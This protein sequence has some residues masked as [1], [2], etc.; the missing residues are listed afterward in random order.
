MTLLGRKKECHFLNEVFSSQKAEFIAIYGRRRVGKTYLINEFFQKKGVFFELTGRKNATKSAQL[1]NFKTVLSDLFYQG[2]PVITPK[3]WDEAL[4]SLRYQIDKLD[5]QEKIILFFDELPWLASKKSGF[6]E[7]LDLFWNRYMSRKNNVILIVC[8]SAAEW[9]IKKVVSN[10]SGLH[11]RLTKPPINLRPFTLQETEEY[12]ASSGV[13]LDRKQIIDIYMA[14]GGVAYYLDLVPKGK[15]SSEIISEL[16]FIHQAPLLVEFNNLFH[17]L[18]DNSEKHI[19]II[20]A[21]AKTA[22][23]LT[24]SELFNEVK[25]LSVGGSSVSILE[26]LEHCGFISLLP[27][28]GKKKKNTRYR[29]TDPFTLFYIKWVEGIRQVPELYWNRKKGSP[30]YH[31]WAGYAFENICFW[32]YPELISALGIS[33]SAE[34]Y[35]SWKY[36][37]PMYSEEKGTQIDLVIDRADSCINLVEIKFYNEEFIIDKSY[38]EVLMHKKNCFKEKTKTRKTIFLTIITPYGVKKEANYLN[39]IDGQITINALFEK[40]FTLPN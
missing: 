15:S 29:L 3:N 19:A 20:K 6:L 22:Q 12:L 9:M 23:G 32:H 28:F 13:C 2:G 5:S 39:C 30:S 24:Q 34:M 26:E 4:N 27:E 38:A 36:V 11:N 10:K 18:Y 33:I 25:L 17:S 37:P 31:T 14:L 35:S 8:G 1:Y 16:F 40:P 7:A 21:L